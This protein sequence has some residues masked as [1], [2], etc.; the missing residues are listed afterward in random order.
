V[1]SLNIQ[2]EIVKSAS[3]TLAS[4]ATDSNQGSTRFIRPEGYSK[5]YLSEIT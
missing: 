3:P 1:F 5:T 4:L 2:L